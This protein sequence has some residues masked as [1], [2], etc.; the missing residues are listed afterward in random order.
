MSSDVAS[1]HSRNLGKRNIYSPLKQC[2]PFPYLVGLMTGVILSTLILVRPDAQYVNNVYVMISVEGDQTFKSEKLLSEDIL[3][4]ERK[5]P[6]L[7]FD[8]VNMKQQINYVIIRDP[9]EGAN[10]QLW[11]LDVAELNIFVPTGK[12]ETDGKVEMVSKSTTVTHFHSD[13]VQLSPLVVLWRVCNKSLK[14]FHWI[15]FGPSSVYINTHGLESYLTQLDSSKPVWLSGLAPDNKTCVWNSG[16]VFS[17]YALKLVCP[18]ISN[19]ISNAVANPTQGNSLVGCVE[20]AIGYT[21]ATQHP[22][23]VSVCNYMNNK[24]SQ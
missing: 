20:E 10:E 24:I 15:F 3:R 14:Q 2:R 16:I 23:N 1:Y 8:E 9:M 6:H 4:L 11:E 21:C 22:D 17:Y 5:S 13:V 7:L 18:A 12:P 19:C